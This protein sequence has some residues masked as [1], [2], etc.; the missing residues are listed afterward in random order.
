MY[1]VVWSFVCWLSHAHTFYATCVQ[2]PGPR[3]FLSKKIWH[4]KQIKTSKLEYCLIV[5]KIEIVSSIAGKSI[6][7]AGKSTTTTKFM[8]YHEIYVPGNL[9]TMKFMNYH[10]IYELPWNLWTTMKFMNYHEIYVQPWNL[11][12]T[13]KFMNYEIY[14]LP[15]NLW[16]TMK[17]MNYHEIYELPC[18]LLT[19]MKCMPSGQ[20]VSSTRGS[21]NE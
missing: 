12:T 2:G 19:T 16:T 5:N 13:M 11:W 9:W 20:S 6:I 15:W 18:N 3:T 10:G 21:R 4:C 14:E 7:A 8:N 17:F 1:F